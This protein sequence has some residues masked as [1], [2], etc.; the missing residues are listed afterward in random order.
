MLLTPE[1][2]SMILIAPAS[3]PVLRQ[4]WMPMLRRPALLRELWELLTSVDKRTMSHVNGTR[5]M[6]ILPPSLSMLELDANGSIFYFLKHVTKYN[7]IFVKSILNT[8]V[9]VFISRL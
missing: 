3:A 9:C 4:T 6:N 1:E 2:Y 7:I 5:F 8:C